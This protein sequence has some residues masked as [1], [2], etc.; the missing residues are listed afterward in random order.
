[1]GVQGRTRLDRRLVPV[2]GGRGVLRRAGRHRRH[3]VSGHPGH[4][5]PE[6]EQQH[7]GYTG[8]PHAG[9][10][11][12]VTPPASARTLRSSCSTPATAGSRSGARPSR[13]KAAAPT[14]AATRRGSCPTI[15]TA[16]CR[17]AAPTRLPTSR[18]SRPSSRSRARPSRSTRY[19]TRPSS[20]PSRNPSSSAAH[21]TARSAS[22]AG[23]STR[24]SA[25]SA[26]SA[27]RTRS[28]RTSSNTAARA[29]GGRRA[30]PA[31]SLC[32]PLAVFRHA[33]HRRDRA[34][35]GRHQAVR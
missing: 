6:V 3:P 8:L 21:N 20:A 16:C 10:L 26:S 27:A 17:R 25:S 28:S 34:R 30:F 29:Q 35:P 24:R 18:R 11:L 2:E 32:R 7:R 1:M 22:R 13:C 12:R 15:F 23:S 5:R 14:A 31:A 19:P 9:F 4:A 33:R